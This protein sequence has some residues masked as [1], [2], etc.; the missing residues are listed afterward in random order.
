[1]RPTRTGTDLGPDGAGGGRL[2][3]TVRLSVGQVE[4]RREAA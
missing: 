3:L 1:M 2:A 4:V